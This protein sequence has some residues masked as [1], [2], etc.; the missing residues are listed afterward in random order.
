MPRRI[1]LSVLDQSPIREGGTPAQGI[2]ETLE[3]AQLCDRLGYRRYGLAEHHNTVGLAGSA[4]EILIGRVAQLT[5]HLRVGSGGVMLSHY[6]AFKVAESFRM[7]ETLYP[8]RIDLGI[9]RAPG[10]DQRTAR[11]LMAGPGALG[12]EYFPNQIMDLMSFLEDSMEADHPF[13]GIHAEPRGPGQPEL[14][15]LGSSDQSAA[16]AAHFGLPF[17]FAHFITDQGGGPVM[18]AYRNQ[19]RASARYP[20]PQG[21]IGVFVICAPTDEE[22]WHLSASRDLWILRLRLGRPGRVPTPEEALSYPYTPQER[23]VVEFNRQRTIAG[24][25]DTVKA[26]LEELA[27]EY[28]VDELVAVTIT[29]DFAARKRSYELLAETFGLERRD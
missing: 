8:G 24:A 3:L 4:P 9:G 28:D 6:S 12:I 16:F 29:Y 2:A 20:A 27:E 23:M 15:M 25:P 18:R 26:R 14:W 22:A 1:V 7:L 17:S 5:K 11:A 21:S 10:S 13:H 19:Y